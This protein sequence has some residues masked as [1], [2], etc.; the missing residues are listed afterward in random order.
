[1]NRFTMDTLIGDA[2]DSRKDTA[3]TALPSSSAVD[4]ATRAV[5]LRTQHGP[6]LLGIPRDGLRVSWRAETTT[7]VPAS[8]G[9]SSP[10]GPKAQS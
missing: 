3:M 9:I 8:S 1:M 7:P 2:A 4:T 6:G 10:K 5:A